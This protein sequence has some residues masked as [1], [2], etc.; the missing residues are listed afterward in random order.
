MSTFTLTTE[1]K[2]SIKNG[3]SLVMHN[4]FDCDSDLFLLWFNDFWGLWVLEK[5][6][7]VIKATKTINPILKKL[8]LDGAITEST[9]INQ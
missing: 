8:N 4:S 1:Q 3:E 7:K 6:A 9:L 5:N 2:Q